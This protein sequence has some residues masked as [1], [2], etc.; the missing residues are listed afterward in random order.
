MWRAVRTLRANPRFALVRA[1]VG[2]YGVVAYATA[3][4]TREMGIRIAL[5][6]RPAS[7]V[8]VAMGQALWAIGAGAIVGV[9][10]ALWLARAMHSMVYDAGGSDVVVF[11]AV[12]CVLL[13]VAA[14]AAYLPARRAGRTDPLIALRSQ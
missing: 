1:C 2:V 6:A 11:I 4:R 14:L 12:P 13:C 10:G 5:G 8:A 7:V 3:Q 9:V